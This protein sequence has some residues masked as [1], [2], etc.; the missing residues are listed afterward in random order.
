MMLNRLD[1]ISS[2]RPRSR[3]HGFS[4]SSMV[5]F[6]CEA[7]LQMLH[8]DHSGSCVG[9][10]VSPL[11]MYGSAK[12]S[13]LSFPDLLKRLIGCVGNHYLL[14]G[15]LIGVEMYR[16]GKDSKAQGRALR[17]HV[18]LCL[19]TYNDFLNLPLERLKLQLTEQ[20]FDWRIDNVRNASA[21][22]GW[23]T[24]CLKG[25]KDP[26]LQGVCKEVLG[27]SSVQLILNSSLD[28][29]WPLDSLHSY[30]CSCGYEVG[31]LVPKSGCKVPS[32]GYSEDPT[33][34]MGDF[35][36]KVCLKERLGLYNGVLHER[37]PG[38]EFTWQ[39]RCKVPGFVTELTHMGLPMEFRHKMFEA[40]STLSSDGIVRGKFKL[41]VYPK[42]TYHSY[43]WEFCDNTV[44]DCRVGKVV[45][46]PDL[47]DS[48]SSCGQFHS[49]L[50][51]DLPWPEDLLCFIT[52]LVGRNNLLSL[53]LTM[54]CLFHELTCRKEH[55]SVWLQGPPDSYKSWFI[56]NFLN[57]LFSESLVYV[58]NTLSE[59]RFMFDCLKDVKDGVLVY[60]DITSRSHLFKNSESLMNLLDG[61]EVA[62]ERKYEASSMVRFL[63]HSAITSNFSIGMCVPHH[64]PALS[65]RVNEYTFSVPSKAPNLN[66]VSK[67]QWVSFG[68]LCNALYLQKQGI[69]ADYP[70]SWFKSR[71]CAVG[72]DLISLENLL[73]FS[74]ND[75]AIGL[76][77]KKV[78]V[79][80][81]PLGDVARGNCAIGAS[82]RS[83]GRTVA[84]RKVRRAR[85]VGRV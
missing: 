84:V 85:R 27:C 21:G 10:T 43:L 26:L 29:K 40:G 41:D 4:A 60:D 31:L 3:K 45:A 37:R 83:V 39:A 17:P 1:S 25:L 79:V 30:L 54:G 32:V 34:H 49:V 57:N 80:A 14:A 62:S 36:R 75:A 20:G 19:F 68:V 52:S 8:T 71:Q 2:Y 74:N 64:A 55:P 73:K 59:R 15:A 16:R 38:T 18:H 77:S 33:L 61:R 7:L 35:V 9:L 78:C 82:P 5:H 46:K 42:V 23:I 65:K 50:W 53:M 51:K 11:R 24:Y 67:E 12:D 76:V 47:L 66:N 28:P 13:W 58:M 44:L 22:A 70:N 69:V 56:D 72:P 63:G 81:L 6:Q 48:F